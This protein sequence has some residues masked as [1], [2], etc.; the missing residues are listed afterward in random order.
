MNISQIV[1]MYSASFTSNEDIYQK[2]R[3]DALVHMLH[4][5]VFWGAIAFFAILIII[6]CVQHLVREYKTYGNL[7]IYDR[8]EKE[9]K[10]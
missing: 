7:S 2:L 1:N 6:P 3:D 5:P 9:V 8:T 4:S 10:K